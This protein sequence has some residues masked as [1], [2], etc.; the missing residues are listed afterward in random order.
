MSPRKRV[1]ITG[2]FNLKRNLREDLKVIF[3]CLKHIVYNVHKKKKKLTL[4]ANRFLLKLKPQFDN[5]SCTISMV[6]RDS[7][8]VT[9]FDMGNA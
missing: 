9:V 7:L 5:Y 1:K 4:L 2:N 8:G 6:Q 3:I